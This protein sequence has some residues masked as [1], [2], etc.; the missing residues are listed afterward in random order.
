MGSDRTKIRVYPY[1]KRQGEHSN[2]RRAIISGFALEGIF[3]G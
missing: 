3:Q 2:G 1:F